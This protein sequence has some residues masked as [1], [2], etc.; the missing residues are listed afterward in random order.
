MTDVGQIVG[1]VPVAGIPLQT[2]EHGAADLYHLVGSFLG[3]GGLTAGQ[4]KEE[5]DNVQWAEL[6][7]IKSRLSNASSYLTGDF[8]TK[9]TSILG[10]LNDAYQGEANDIMASRFQQAQSSASQLA[11]TFSEL[12]SRVADIDTALT[13]CAK[14]VGGYSRLGSDISNVTSHIPLVGGESEDDKARDAWNKCAGS[15]ESTG[16]AMPS[17][18]AGLSTFGMTTPP[19]PVNTQPPAAVPT[20]GAVGPGPGPGPGPVPT[21]HITKPP[22]LKPPHVVTHPDPGPGPGSPGP[23]TPGPGGYGPGGYG[24]GGYGPGGYG[25]GGYGP[26]GPGAGLDTGTEL[27]GYGPG[28]GGPGPGLD[29]GGVGGGTGGVDGSSLAGA[30]GSGLAGGLGGG[31]AGA[32]AAAGGRGGAGGVPMGARGGG[33]GGSD[34]DRE[35]STWLNED[36][37]VWG[38]SDAPDGVI[39]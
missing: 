38:E 23:G 16:S 25:P 20:P 2:W 28:P 35:R 27:A 7:L 17:A 21:P 34:S 9:L 5:M 15:F 6:D 1:Q 13:A 4:L 26:G 18:T 22:H 19:T 12:S 8:Q 30:G 37:D 3:G 11:P 14:S 36:D 32:G 24:P 39:S 33:G 31:A 10:K 29:G